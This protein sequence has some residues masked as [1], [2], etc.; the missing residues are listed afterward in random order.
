M[1]WVKQCRKPYAESYEK[2]RME[3]AYSVLLKLP[4]EQNCILYKVHTQ[5]TM[6]EE[7]FQIT[8]KK[9]SLNEA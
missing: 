6:T 1:A 4:E 7:L 2:C 8:L 5:D 3:Q 9:I